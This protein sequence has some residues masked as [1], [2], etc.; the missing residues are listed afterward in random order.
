M[1]H[2]K[3]DMRSHDLLKAGPANY[4]SFAK[5]LKFVVDK[6]KEKAKFEV[7]YGTLTISFGS[8]HIYET[9]LK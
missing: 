4:Y 9:D 6:V 3:F 5:M 1:I 2:A 8:F 7:E